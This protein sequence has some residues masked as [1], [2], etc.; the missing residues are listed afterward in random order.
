MITARI[1]KRDRFGIAF[2]NPPYV[3]TRDTARDGIKPCPVRGRYLL[4]DWGRKGV[5]PSPDVVSACVVETLGLRTRV[6]I[7]Q[8][9]IELC[10]APRIALPSAC[11]VR[12]C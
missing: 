3:H 8:G 4:T 9:P 2:S 1:D 11:A 7:E 6:A 10:V 5:A 12:P